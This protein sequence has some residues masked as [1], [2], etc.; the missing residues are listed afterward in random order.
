MN[1]KV[2]RKKCTKILEAT[3]MLPVFLRFLD[4]YQIEES[5]SERNNIERE[6]RHELLV[7]LEEFMEA[8]GGSEV[9]QTSEAPALN[10]SPVSWVE[11]D[12]QCRALFGILGGHAPKSRRTLY[13]PKERQIELGIQVFLKALGY[14]SYK[15]GAETIL[16]KHKVQRL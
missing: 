7:H 11:E 4:L 10:H 8:Y 3:G 2:L 12:E 5:K 6:I 15:V 13:Y 14:T 1:K 9:V 16:T